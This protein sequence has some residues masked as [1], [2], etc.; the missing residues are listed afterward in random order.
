MQFEIVIFSLI[1]ALG[2]V[3]TTVEATIYVGFSARR[4]KGYSIP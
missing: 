3:T 4:A 1:P 2:I